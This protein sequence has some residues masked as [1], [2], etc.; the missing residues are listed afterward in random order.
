MALRSVE[1]LS[2]ALDAGRPIEVL[3]FS[4]WASPAWA[5]QFDGCNVRLGRC[6]S[7]PGCT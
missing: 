5:N 1:G 4:T 7:E 2:I 6:A 3:A